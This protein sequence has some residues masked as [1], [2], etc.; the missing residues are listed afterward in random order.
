MPDLGMF[1]VPCSWRDDKILY[2]A[3]FKPTE[4]SK[5]LDIFV[6]DTDGN[7]VQ[8]TDDLAPDFDPKFSPNGMRIAFTSLRDE[9]ANIYCMDADG[10]NV[11]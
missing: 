6:I 4:W 7:I 10:S 3:L 11:Q 8:L 5:N 2:I 9:Y 1:A